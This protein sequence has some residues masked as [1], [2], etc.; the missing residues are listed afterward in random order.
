MMKPFYE[1]FVD[2]KVETIEFLI[3]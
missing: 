2:R 3:I 1:K